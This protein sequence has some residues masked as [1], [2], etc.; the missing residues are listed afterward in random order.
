MSKYCG[1]DNDDDYVNDADSDVSIWIIDK[2]TQPKWS[3]ENNK[4]RMVVWH[5]KI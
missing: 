2:L 3:T 4:Q 1:G 5:S